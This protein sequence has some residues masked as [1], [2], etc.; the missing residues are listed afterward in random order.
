MEPRPL[1]FGGSPHQTQV[2]EAGSGSSQ[3]DRELAQVP[4]TY[5]QVLSARVP[6]VSPS[7][8]CSLFSLQR[9]GP[10]AAGEAV[11]RAVMVPNAYRGLIWA[12]RLGEIQLVIRRYSHNIET[13]KGWLRYLDADAQWGLAASRLSYLGPIPHVKMRQR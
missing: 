12:R 6:C 2:A 3:N 5:G 10:E 4:E 11:D 7:P 9:A 8:L 1:S 13:R